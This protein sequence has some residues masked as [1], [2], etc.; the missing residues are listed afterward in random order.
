MTLHHDLTPAA[1]TPSL[2]ERGSDAESPG[3]AGL[4]TVRTP[5]THA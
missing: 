4:S 3:I 2:G 1:Y 5:G